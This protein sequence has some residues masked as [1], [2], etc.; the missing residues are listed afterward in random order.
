M[1]PIRELRRQ[2]GLSSKDLAN[3]VGIS[4]SYVRMIETS[5]CPLTPKILS[6]IAFELNENEKR[7]SCTI[8]EWECHRK[9]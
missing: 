4:E 6:K 5:K 8:Q 7:L 2:R 1:H 9:P 3:K